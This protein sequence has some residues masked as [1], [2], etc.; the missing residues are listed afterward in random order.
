[1]I[2]PLF[3]IYLISATKIVPASSNPKFLSCFIIK[4]LAFITFSLVMGFLKN[5][6]LWYW[7][8]RSLAYLTL[9]STTTFSIPLDEYKLNTALTISGLA[10]DRCS[11]LIATRAP[12]YLLMKFLTSCDGLIIWLKSVINCAGVLTKIGVNYPV[13][14]YEARLTI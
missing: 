3:S 5:P 6:L 14:T 13:P 10:F 11:D 9:N 7:V 4:L 12:N 1:M 8:L 2:S